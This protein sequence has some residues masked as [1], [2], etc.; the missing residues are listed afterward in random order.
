LTF[1][2]IFEIRLRVGSFWFKFFSAGNK[3]VDGPEKGR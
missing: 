1:V 3:G 2:R